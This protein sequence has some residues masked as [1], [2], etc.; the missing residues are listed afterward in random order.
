MAITGKWQRLRQARIEMFKEELK[1]RKKVDEEL[2]LAEMDAKH[3]IRW[4]TGGSYLR[5]LMKLGKVR[6]NKDGTIEWVRDKKTRKRAL[7]P[8]ST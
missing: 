4:V 2:F 3:G 8:P 6:K 1:E 5:T 7:H